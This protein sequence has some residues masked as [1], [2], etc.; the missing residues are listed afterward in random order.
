MTNFE[1][2]GLLIG[3]RGYV[4]MATI[5]KYQAGDIVK[6][7]D[8]DIP[9]LLNQPFIVFAETD[10]A[11]FQE[12]RRVAGLGPSRPPGHNQRYYRCTTD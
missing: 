7:V 3:E 10:R 6:P 1:R 11:D 8:P 5:G 2:V 9:E 12:Q 4:V